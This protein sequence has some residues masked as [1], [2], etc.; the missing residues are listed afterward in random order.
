YFGIKGLEEYSFG[1]KSVEQAEELK[2]HI[3]QQ[4]IKEG[5]QDLSYVVVGGGPTGVELAGSLPSYIRSVAKNHGLPRRKVHVD[6][7]EAAPRLLPR[8]PKDISRAVRKHLRRT[9]VKIYL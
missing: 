6:L 1:V 8:M 7:I 2:R 5:R 3:H 4:M 9:G